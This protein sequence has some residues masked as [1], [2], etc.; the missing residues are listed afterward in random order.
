MQSKKESDEKIKNNEKGVNTKKVQQKPLNILR[1]TMEKT[2]NYVGD[3][4]KTTINFAEKS[5]K[6]VQKVLDDVRKGLSDEQSRK[7]LEK[8]KP[9]FIDNIPDSYPKMI[10]VVDYDKRMA[11]KEC[12]KAVGFEDNINGMEILGIY[13]KEISKF[14]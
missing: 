12:E 3:A 8:Y 1:E 13:K 5:L 10:N 2:Y 6:E 9:I 4:T 14:S 11:I 7:K